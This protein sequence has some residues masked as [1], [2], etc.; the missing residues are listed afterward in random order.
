[1]SRKKDFIIT[2]KLKLSSKHLDKNF[3]LL[4]LLTRKKYDKINHL[5]GYYRDLAHELRIPCFGFKYFHYGKHTSWDGLHPE[6]CH[7]RVLAADFRMAFK[8]LSKKRHR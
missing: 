7:I 6:P 5:N 3:L 4:K 1:M 8:N 2:Y